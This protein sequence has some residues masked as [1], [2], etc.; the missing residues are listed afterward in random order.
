MCISEM[1]LVYEE[2]CTSVQQSEFFIHIVISDSAA[3]NDSYQEIE[4]SQFLHWNVK[5]QATFKI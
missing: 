5:Q 2:S 3:G 1:H 4:S